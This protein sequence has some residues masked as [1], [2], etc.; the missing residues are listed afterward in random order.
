[1]LIFCVCAIDS[2]CEYTNTIINIYIPISYLFC[3]SSISVCFW[4]SNTLAP[5]CE[6]PTLGKIEGRKEGNDKGWDGWMAPL[7][8]WI[9]VWASSRRWSFRTGKPGMLQYMG[10]Q[11]VRHN[12]ETEQQK[13]SLFERK[14]KKLETWCKKL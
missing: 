8:Q 7:T 1:M 13:Q 2:L 9:W 12:L 6:R 14:S 5:W 3:L 10:S 4:S 11:R